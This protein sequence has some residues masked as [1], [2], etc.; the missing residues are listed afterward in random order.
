MPGRGGGG[1][2]LGREA[3]RSARLGFFFFASGF[4]T[5]STN[6]MSAASISPVP[7]LSFLGFEATGIMGLAEAWPGPGLSSVQLVAGGAASAMGITS[8]TSTS[9]SSGSTE[10]TAVGSL[11]FGTEAPGRGT[12]RRAGAVRGGLG[13][14]ASGAESKSLASS[15]VST[16]SWVCGLSFWGLEST[17]MIGRDMMTPLGIGGG[18]VASGSF[19]GTTGSKRALGLRHLAKSLTSPARSH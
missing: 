4:S 9:I 2:F 15:S 19:L 7:G 1:C 8:S 10:S 11:V 5:S 12:E 6:S 16:R 3:S 14:A 18:W 17:G 13:F